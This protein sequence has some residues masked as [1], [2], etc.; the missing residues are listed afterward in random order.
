MLF[1]KELKELGETNENGVR[2]GE[3]KTYNDKDFLIL[4]GSYMDGVKHGVWLEYCDYTKNVIVATT[5]YIE[6]IKNGAHTSYYLN[7][8]I[9]VTGQYINDIPDGNWLEYDLDGNIHRSEFYKNGKR[10]GAWKYYKDGKIIWVNNYSNGKPYGWFK[11]FRYDQNVMEGVYQFGLKEGIWKY[12][13]ESA[14]IGAMGN[15]VADKMDGV[16]IYYDTDFLEIG[17]A[18]FCEGVALHKDGEVYLNDEDIMDFCE[19]FYC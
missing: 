18:I 15:Y 4:Q 8:T 19:T 6:G 5:Q 1:N 16:W 12:Y 10:E 9:H 7:E 17:K 3:W 13:H 14:G 11:L 2:V